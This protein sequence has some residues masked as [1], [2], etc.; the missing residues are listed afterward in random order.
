MSGIPL[1]FSLNTSD[2][3]MQIFAENLSP[4][5]LSPA[6][7]PAAAA[8]ISRPTTPIMQETNF[9]RDD[10]IEVDPAVPV[11]PVGVSDSYARSRSLPRRL[12]STGNRF[13]TRYCDVMILNNRLMHELYFA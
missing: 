4:A 3:F 8:E 1:H 13:N 11:V 6:K 10:S 2:F 9:G 7:E 5:N 12:P